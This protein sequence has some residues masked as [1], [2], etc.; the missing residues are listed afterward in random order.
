VLAG[1]IRDNLVLASPGMVDR[2]CREV[3]A[4]VN[5]LQ[6]IDEHPDGLD[7]AV[8]DGGAGLSGGER[9]RL[10]IARALA[11]HTELLLLDEPT[12]SLDGRNERALHDAIW[13]AAASRTVIVVAHRLATVAHADQIVVI[14]AGHVVSVGTH[15][16]LLDRSP[17]Y[18]ELAQDQLLK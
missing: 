18:R 6:R 15:A 7:A 8:G 2:R 16:E 13:S 9:Q 1:T 5:L 14:E 11:S 4:S 3:L 17:L 12:A 10:A